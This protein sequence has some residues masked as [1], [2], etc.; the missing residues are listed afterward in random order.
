MCRTRF[1]HTRRQL[2]A[3]Q[4]RSGLSVLKTQPPPAVHTGAQVGKIFFVLGLIDVG[5]RLLNPNKQQGAAAADGA[6]KKS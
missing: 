2:F 5:N 4:A 6:T 1:L 3:L